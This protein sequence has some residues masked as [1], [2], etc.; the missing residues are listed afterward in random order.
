MKCL[1]VVVILISTM[2][3]G[4]YVAPAT[5]EEKQVISD[6][7]SSRKGETFVCPKELNT[8]DEQPTTRDIVWDIYSAGFI[9]GYT[10]SVDG[11]NCYEELNNRMLKYMEVG[12]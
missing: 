1:T 6:R 11:K 8:T 7:L 10:A 12:K 4:C 5:T 3:S 9:H 2:I